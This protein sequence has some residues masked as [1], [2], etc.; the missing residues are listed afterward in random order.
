MSELHGKLLGAELSG[1]FSASKA[2]TRQPRAQGAFA[3]RGPDLPA[4]INDDRVMPGDGFAV[5]GRGMFAN[6]HD[7]T[8]KHDRALSLPATRNATADRHSVLGA[9]RSPITGRGQFAHRSGWPDADAILTQVVMGAA[10]GALEQASGDQIKDALH[11]KR[12]DAPKNQ[13]NF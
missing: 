8:L 1:S 10:P 9:D 7:A 3:A 5:T 11:G 13:R 12:G 2:S 6:L 4:L